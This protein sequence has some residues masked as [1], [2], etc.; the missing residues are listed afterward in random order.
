MLF[1][2]LFILCCV[3]FALTLDIRGFSL[4]WIPAHLP[5]IDA[6]RGVTRIS[7]VLLFPIGAILGFIVMSFQT[8]I[9]QR[10][11]TIHFLKKEW[12]NAILALTSVLIVGLLFLDQMTTSLVAME[13]SSVKHRIEDLRREVLAIDGDVVSNKNMILWDSGNGSDPMWVT[14]VDAL[15]VSQRLNIKTI[16]GYGSVIPPAY[17]DDLYGLYGNK[18]QA[19]QDWVSKNKLM[20]TGKVILIIGSSCKTH[21]LKSKT[22]YVTF[23]MAGS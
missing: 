20:F 10:I 6:I 9:S 13:K 3:I 5:V 12:K 23:M 19:M 18:C 11:E 17:G 7:L 16:N 15:L 2:E 21:L 8:I 4:Y 22:P 14:Q 1:F